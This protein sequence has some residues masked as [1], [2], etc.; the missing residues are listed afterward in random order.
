MILIGS[1]GGDEFTGTDG[2]DN[3]LV[4]LAGNDVLYG[5]SGN[6]ELDGGSGDDTLHS[7]P[8]GFE[9]IDGGA[10]SDL[11]YFSREGATV[12]L[13]F[14]ADIDPAVAFSP[15]TGG[16]IVNVEHFFVSGTRLGASGF[17]DTL[18]GG[19]GNDTLVTFAGHDLLL[20][21]GGDDSITAYPA[22]AET[23]DG[24]EGSDT[25]TVIGGTDHFL[26][27][28]AGVD[29]VTLFFYQSVNAVVDITP[30]AI[31]T[32]SDRTRVH[33][34]E[35]FA[36][37]ASATGSHHV[38]L[39]NGNDLIQGEGGLDTF[40]G[41]GGN[42]TISSPGRQGT[43]TILHGDAGDDLIRAEYNPDF[44]QP[45]TDNVFAIDGGTGEDTLFIDFSSARER[46]VFRVV[47]AVDG[48]ITA[49]NGTTV[50]GIEAFH[51]TGSE[52][53]DHLAGGDGNDTILGYADRNLLLGGDGNDSIT[54]GPFGIANG[55]RLLGGNGD[56]T[57]VARAGNSS[58][59]GGAGNDFLW[60]E[61]ANNPDAGP[62]TLFGGSG[63][64]LI[65][66]PSGRLVAGTVVDGG[67]GIDTVQLHLGN[68]TDTSIDISQIAQSRT[69]IVPI[70][71][72]LESIE[73]GHILMGSGNDT[74]VGGSWG[75]T[76]SGGNGDDSISGFLG[77]DQLVGE[78]GNDTLIGGDGNDTIGVN[79]GGTSSS[80]L[81]MDSVSGNAGNDFISIAS[82]ARADGGSGYDVLE[83]YSIFSPTGVTVAFST[84]ATVWQTTS[85]GATYRGFEALR[86]VGG[87]RND[88]FTGAGGSDTLLGG[89]GNN[90]LKG[91]GGNDLLTSS[92][93]NSTLSGGNGDD[94]LAVYGENGV[95]RG[96]AGRDLF[97][98]DAVSGNAVAAVRDF[99]HG[100]DHIGIS[101]ANFFGA[102]SF[103][104][105]VGR[106]PAA[107]GTGPALLFDTDTSLLSFDPDGSG[108][109]NFIFARLE[110]VTSLAM[111]DF[112][113]V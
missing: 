111:S 45:D 58:L 104:L 3:R 62:D 1:A 81:G 28:G 43:T 100:T 84:D 21:R 35:E 41:G 26:I 101:K 16:T 110:G 65:Q 25:I 107:T 37:Y 63:D 88:Q 14:V 27:G 38:A 50:R 90:L 4:G 57:L 78:K 32:F 77:D 36:V 113:L 10:G 53:N 13:R 105:F 98:F 9:T 92:L 109:Y 47:D 70:G 30:D 106:D 48:L 112:I 12:P 93:G 66:T 5:R 89:G 75:D 99:T 91:A 72:T 54:E 86:I 29:Q 95:L 8:A 11:L 56:D 80:D 94:T 85:D 52:K 73:R 60:I 7:G 15:S 96:G 46:V 87:S 39:G 51:I 102:D 59:N 69:I 67:G 82:G 42:D 2:E 23:I 6:D 20:G 44:D 33:G 55:S 103:E 83:Y 19:N 79:L 108:S 24:G 17:G 61:S 68:T 71:L 97:Q 34:I 49:S 64:D 22:A 31:S 76:L 74:V 18:A 40:A